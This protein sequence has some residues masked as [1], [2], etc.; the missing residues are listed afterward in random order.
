MTIQKDGKSIDV[1]TQISKNGLLYVL[2]RDTGEPIYEIEEVEVPQSDLIGE[3]SWPTQPI[4]SVWPKFSRFQLTEDDLA[5]RSDSARAYA[6]DIWQSSKPHHP[7]QPPSKEGTII[8]PGYDGGGEWGGAAHDPEGILYVNTNEMPWLNVMN[9]VK[10]SSR[11]EDLYLTHCA[12]CH[13]IKLEGGELF[14]NVPSLVNL[15]DRLSL[16]ETRS[17]IQNGKGV[18]PSFQMISDDDAVNIYNF[19]NGLDQSSEKTESSWPYPYRMA[20]YKKLYAPD[21]YP[22]I[23]PPWGQL[24]AIDMNSAEIKWQIPLGEH[25]ELTEQ[26]MP[27]TGTENYGGPVVTA[28]DLIF[29]AATMDEKIRAFHKNTGELLW[30]YDLPAAGYATPATYMVNDVQYVVIACGGGKLGTKSGDEYV[31]FALGQ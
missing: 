29:I 22:M 25:E 14:G 20:G 19:I 8:F 30:S 10:P 4:P 7:F 5:V 12:N 28:G 6:L 26:G 9:P 27:I 13:G 18:M 2:D 24:T 15:S 16:V 1:V 3:Q 17:I 23:T 31:A 21:G 11:G